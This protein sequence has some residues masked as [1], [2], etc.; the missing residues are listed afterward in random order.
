MIFTL[1]IKTFHDRWKGLLGWALGI[2]AIVSIQLSVYPTVRKSAAGIAA[3]LENYPETLRQIFRM[4]DYTTGE[5][6]LSTELFSMMIPLIFISVAASW[7]SHASAVEEE[8]RTADLLLTLPISRSR[9]LVSKIFSGVIAQIILALVLAGVLLIGIGIVDLRIDSSK[10]FAGAFTS[11]L[12]GIIF[13]SVSVLFGAL[14]ARKS[15]SLGGAISIALAGFLFYSLS[16]IVDTFDLI[17]PF[18]PFQWTLGSQPLTN[19]IDFGYV[20]LCLGVSTVIYL[21]S[22]FFFRRRDISS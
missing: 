4:Q 17:T 5:G 20:A 12:I 1:V 11:V 19:G 9:I 16:P 6:Y 21:L 2:T 22:I 10:I 15:V 8:R 7:G 3:F 14:N 13:H 18:N